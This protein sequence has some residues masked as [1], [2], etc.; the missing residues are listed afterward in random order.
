MARALPAVTA[1]GWSSRRCRPAVERS[2]TRRCDNAGPVTQGC[3]SN[4]GHAIAS[5]AARIA[6]WTWSS[7]A[8]GVLSV[9]ERMGLLYLIISAAL[10]ATRAP[11]FHRARPY[12]HHRVRQSP[13]AW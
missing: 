8:I 2:A 9:R 5:R 10:D 4:V 13:A 3:V 6:G 11:R 7:R 1:K 12:D